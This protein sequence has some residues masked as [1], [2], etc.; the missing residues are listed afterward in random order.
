MYILL[1]KS[2]FVCMCM[3][4]CMLGLVSLS[5]IHIIRIGDRLLSPI[6]IIRVGD[7]TTHSLDLSLYLSSYTHTHTHTHTIGYT[8]KG[9]RSDGRGVEDVRPIDIGTSLLPNAHGSTLFTRGETQ[10][11]ATAT[12][13]SKVSFNRLFVELL[14]IILKGLLSYVCMCVYVCMY[15]C[16]CVCL[17]IR[18]VI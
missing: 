8:S 1:L 15:V 9:T 6:R 10:S 13:G 12:L 14:P 7:N 18:M 3:C 4:M 17:V 2:L 11:L 16:M 5:P